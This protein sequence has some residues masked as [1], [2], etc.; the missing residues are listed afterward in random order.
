M[1]K[2][3][4][5][6]LDGTLLMEKETALRKDIFALILQLKERGILFA[7]ASGRRYEELKKLFGREAYDMIFV[8][9]NGALILYRENILYQRSIPKAISNAFLQELLQT[10][11]FEWLA[12]GVRT[13]YTNSKNKEYL[14]MLKEKGLHPMQINGL[15]DIPEAI[16]RIS[17]YRAEEITFEKW[18]TELK[19]SYQGEDWL[20]FTE[21]EVNKGLALQEVRKRFLKNGDEVIAFGNGDNDKEMLALAEH[22]YFLTKEEGEMPN[23]FLKHLLK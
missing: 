18:K 5:S 7:V 17:V 16:V 2:L 23:F 6:D 8:C 4:I 12:A 13:C 22:A 19:L 11:A 21:K 10:R 14:A 1:I 15:R 9:E 20:D 3:M